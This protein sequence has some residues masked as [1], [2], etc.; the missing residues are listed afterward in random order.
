MST[1]Q[2][3]SAIAVGGTSF[4]S[5]VQLAANNRIADAFTVV[6]PGWNINSIR[7]YLYQTNGTNV[8]L[9][10]PTITSVNFRIWDGAPGNGDG[11]GGTVAFNGGTVTP[12]VTL[13]DIFR[14]SNTL[15]NNF[16]RQIQF[17][18]ITGLNINLGPGSYH[19]D[20]SATGTLTSGPWQAQLGLPNATGLVAGTGFQSVGNAAFAPVE[21]GPGFRA[22]FPF[23]IEGT[24]VIPEPG[25]LSIL[26]LGAIVGLFRRRR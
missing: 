6:G 2:N 3:R 12:T 15:N 10:A 14:T 20:W 4:G 21:A 8:A 11:T 18:D 9:T 16:Q 5:G 23:L 17:V 7:L 19:L 26:A 1:G 13:S 25:A 24:Q 22:S